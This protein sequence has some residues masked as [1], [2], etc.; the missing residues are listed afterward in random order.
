MEP[1]LP[2]PN[3]VLEEIFQY[4]SPHDLCSCAL[5]CKHF[6]SI[7]RSQSLW[8]G[9]FIPHELQP[10]NTAIKGDEND[11]GAPSPRVCNCAVVVGSSMWIHGGG[12]GDPL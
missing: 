3:E 8:D 6:L 4:L 9:V 12:L 10:S 2:L 7:V 1:A 11:P 5:V